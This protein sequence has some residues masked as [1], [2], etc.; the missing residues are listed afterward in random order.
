M[1]ANDLEVLGIMDDKKYF[2]LKLKRDFFK[3]HDIRII[4]DMPNGKEYILFYLKLLCESVDHEGSLRFSETIPYNDNMLSTIT[5]TNVDVVRNAIKIF[6]ELKMM[7]LLDD[8]TIFMQECQKMMGS[9][10]YWASQKRKQRQKLDNVQQMSND[11]PTCP[12]KSIDIDIDKELDIDIYNNTTILEDSNNNILGDE[13]VV[14]FILK[15]WNS[16]LDK[17]EEMTDAL[18]NLIKFV[19]NKLKPNI[20]IEAIRHY[21]I[22]FKSKYFYS[23][24]WDLNSFL[25]SKNGIVKFLEDGEIWKNFQ[26]ACKKDPLILGVDK[27]ETAGSN[28]AVKKFIDSI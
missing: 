4:E 19:S 1:C 21:A 5:N 2:W 3:R 8:G 25:K 22:V 26:D 23:H 12:S 13:V 14:P 28:A 20:V 7:E 10:T 16:E 24:E 15:I 11:C 17:Q 27:I 18:W 9:E 6:S